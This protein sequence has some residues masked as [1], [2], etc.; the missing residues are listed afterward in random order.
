MPHYRFRLERG[1][2]IGRELALDLPD[3]SVVGHVAKQVARRMASDDLRGGKLDLRQELAV[4][5][6]DGLVIARYTLAEFIE[7]L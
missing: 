1:N 3:A 7:M 6:D 2:H 4:R 5:G